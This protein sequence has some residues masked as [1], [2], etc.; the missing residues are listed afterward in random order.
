MP[1]LQTF[2]VLVLYNIS[3]LPRQNKAEHYGIIVDHHLTTNEMKIFQQI[4]LQLE[5]VSRLHLSFEVFSIPNP[6]SLNAKELKTQFL[7]I[8]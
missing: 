7:P 5:S 4:Y 6:V 3:P 8:M 1:T 2:I